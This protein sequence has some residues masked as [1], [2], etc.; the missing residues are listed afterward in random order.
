[1]GLRAAALGLETLASSLFLIDLV[2]SVSLWLAKH[3]RAFLCSLMR[4][5]GFSRPNPWYMSRLHRFPP[6]LGFNFA[7]VADCNGAGGLLVRRVRE[8][9]L[10]R[11]PCPGM[12]R[13]LSMAPVVRIAPGLVS[14][15]RRYSS[16]WCS[17]GAGAQASVYLLLSALPSIVL[18]AWPE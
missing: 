15:G 17:A 11:C 18:L 10:Y 2:V 9:A 4:G 16:G 14:L 1:M 8:E 12:R 13:H 7:C 6:A 5:V 3:W